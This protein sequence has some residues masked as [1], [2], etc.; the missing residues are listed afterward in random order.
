[1]ES[2]LY[3]IFA[4]RAAAR[5]PSRAAP[6]EAAAL[7]LA[8]LDERLA[9][10]GRALAE[11]FAARTDVFDAQ[12]VV[13]LA[14]GLAPLEDI[15]LHDA[16]RDARAPTLDVIRA[17]SVLQL[18][19]SFARRAPEDL[20]PGALLG[21]PGLPAAGQAAGR[22]DEKPAR[23]PPPV[24]ETKSA[25]LRPWEMPYLDDTDTASDDPDA[26]GGDAADLEPLD[27]GGAETAE[28]GAGGAGAF[29]DIAALN[30]R[31]GRALGAFNDL[32]GTSGRERLSLADL[33]YD[34]AGRLDAWKQAVAAT[35]DLP[36]ALAAAIALDAWLTL[37]PSR[38][39]GELGFL[40]AA[41]VLRRR[42]LAAAHLP[43]LAL[44]LRQNRWRWRPDIAPQAR[45]AGL[46]AAMNEAARLGNAELDRLSLARAVMLA[47]C[48]GK[49]KNARLPELVALFLA[50]PLVS[51]QTAAKALKV[52]PQ[53][54]E[55]MLADLGA[56]LP[57]ER[58]GRKRYRAWGIL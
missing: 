21:R 33:A 31:A 26:D 52:S 9:R 50:T 8:R 27:P 2:A 22:P 7:A 46:V 47:K 45:L 34:E 5:A 11:G 39:Q 20:S 42:G 10:G 54:I 4:A 13:T 1:M 57:P 43:A 58:T 12:A 44:G 40:L 35:A 29:A 17:V 28:D 15:V 37:Q 49:S 6:L 19:R 48:A 36:A 30:A 14:G 51:V 32:R 3:D 16:G 41:D 38:H 53:G 55:A 56:A 23:L 18:R 24:R 25:R